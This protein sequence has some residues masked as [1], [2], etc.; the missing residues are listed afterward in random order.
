MTSAARD[1][2]EHSGVLPLGSAKRDAVRSMF[3]SIA[4]RY[5][6]V[7]K[8]MTFGL[9]VRW[10]RRTLRL[11]GL[12]E[13]S[14]VL[15]LGCGT[16][17][18]SRELSCSGR[19]AVGVDI[20]RGMLARARPGGA[21]LV[22]GDAVE[23]PFRS[24]LF[25]GAVSGFALRNLADLGG[26]F[27]ELARVVHPGGRIAL[28]DVA[29]PEGAIARLGHKLW[30][31]RAA[32]RIGGLLSDADAY[33]YLPRSLAYLPQPSALDEMLASAGFTGRGRRVLPPGAVQ[34]LTACRR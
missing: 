18:L 23:L 2:P 7:N 22:L 3:D 20:S 19:R 27:A 8:L 4:P 26:A 24:G 28:L 11:L 21:S 17:D 14:L 29:Q 16:G 5:D 15:D 13:G 30:F 32:P 10:R 6:L 34:V 33:R 31:T 9:D 12:P 1:L 25:D